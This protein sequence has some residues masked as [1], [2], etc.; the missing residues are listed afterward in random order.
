MGTIRERQSREYR[1]LRDEL[2]EA[3]T[4]LIEQREHVADLRRKLPRGAKLEADYVLREGPADWSRNDESDFFDTRL[5]D[6]FGD[7]RDELIVQHM[8]FA[9]DA[10][11]GCPMCSMW[12]DGLDGVAH[13]LADRVG[14][15]VVARAPLAKLRNWAQARGWRRLR[16]LSSSE[17]DFNG[18][19]GAEISP[20]RQLPG[21]SVFSRDPGGD[22]YHRYTSEGSLVERHHR[23]MDL[24]TPVWSLLDLLP[25]GRGNWMPKHF[26]GD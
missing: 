24:Y 23:A 7:G 8:M 26:Y 19:L 18:D 6:L 21:L 14:F 12:A 11:K 3:E 16:V 20:D 2:L 9:P 13:H 22:L 17:S 25:S 10:E 4:V 15:A 1:E 5:S